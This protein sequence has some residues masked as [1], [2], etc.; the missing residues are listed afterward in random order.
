MI[1]FRNLGLRLLGESLMRNGYLHNFKVSP[2]KI[3]NYKE[4][5]A[6]F[7]EDKS[8]DRHH[9]NQVINVNITIIRINDIVCLLT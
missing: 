8:D 5:K 2:Y 1:F 4:N 3:L 9:Y 7:T 6:N